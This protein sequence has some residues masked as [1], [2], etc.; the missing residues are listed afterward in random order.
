MDL[1]NKVH[2]SNKAQ[3]AHLKVDK[4]LTKVFIKYA[5]FADVFLPKLAAKLPKYMKINN[6]AFKLVD[7]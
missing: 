2:P 4:A 6:H 3:I 7:D 1:S 5:N